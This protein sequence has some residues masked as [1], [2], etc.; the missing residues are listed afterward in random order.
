MAMTP[1]LD[2]RQSQQLVMTPQLQQAIKMLQYSNVELTE[3]VESEMEKNP[4]LN[5]SEGDPKLS[6]AS[7]GNTERVELQ[8][9]DE[10]LLNVGQGNSE[11]EVPLDTDFREN[12]F[13]S[14]SASDSP[15]STSN[16]QLGFNG[17]GTIKGGGGGFDDNRS[18]EQTIGQ[19]PSLKDFLSDQ[20]KIVPLL[21]TDQLI[22]SYLIEMVTESGYLLENISDLHEQLECEEENVKRVVQTLQGLEPVGI[23]ARNLSECLSIQLRDLDRLDPCMKALV[24]NLDLLGKRDFS[25]LKRLCGVG[26]EDLKDMVG[27]IQNLNPKPGLAFAGGDPIQPVVPDLFV[28]KNLDGKWTVELNSDTLPKVLISTSYYAELSSKG[29]SKEDK[30]YIS[31]CYAN[32][33]WLVKALDQRARTILKVGSELVRQQEAFFNR[34]VRY[35]VP[36]NLKA[37]A[38]AIDMHESTVSRVTANKFLGTERGIFEMKY[39]FTA[40]IGASAGND[41]FSAEA[42]R[43][44]IK[45][46]IDVED[47]KNILSDDK[48]VEILRAR[49]IDI[50]RRTVAKYREAMHIP[51]SVQRRR[52]KNLK[53][54]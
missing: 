52:Q 37:I 20:L 33:N 17:T 2:L 24:D 10:A 34:G 36:L 29:G 43:F 53:L 28:R 49:G 19:N 32:A 11:M 3:F 23:F 46:L 9:A 18:F 27:E 39:F 14:D 21:Q 12:V 51:S 6:H 1:C 40:S 54:E 31:D 48:I 42:V 16:D 15:A 13:N 47:P 50:A 44:R 41:S 26:S 45:E 35:L 8:G 38:D 7:D 25:A 22:A 30:A 4:L 5:Q